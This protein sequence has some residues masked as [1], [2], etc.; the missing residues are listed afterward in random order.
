MLFPETD[1]ALIWLLHGLCLYLGS[2]LEKWPWQA[3]FLKGSSLHLRSVSFFMVQLRMF[4]E[5]YPMLSNYILEFCSIPCNYI[6]K[7]CHLIMQQFEWLG[8]N[9]CG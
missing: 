8:V 3:A 4:T 1:P 2:S 5:F 9:G 7:L 6:L